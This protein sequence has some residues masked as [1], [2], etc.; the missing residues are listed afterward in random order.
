MRNVLLVAAAAVLSVTGCHQNLEVVQPH[1]M[2]TATRIAMPADTGFVRR[3]CTAPDSV[4][5][6]KA[7]CY[8]RGQKE[9]LR[10]F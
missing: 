2:P 1:L 4:L 8:E 3:T 7:P 9:R 6:G 5:A 10:L